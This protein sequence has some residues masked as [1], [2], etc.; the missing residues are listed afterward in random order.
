MFCCLFFWGGSLDVYKNRR[1]GVMFL[2]FPRKGRAGVVEWEAVGGSGGGGD[3]DA[4]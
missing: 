1:F 2:W 3:G 4:G